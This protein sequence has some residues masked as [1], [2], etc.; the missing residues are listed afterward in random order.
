MQDDILYH[1]IVKRITKLNVKYLKIYNTMIFNICDNNLDT[2]RLDDSLK[3]LNYKL[4][5]NKMIL[6]KISKDYLIQKSSIDNI[7]YNLLYCVNNSQASKE[8]KASTRKLLN[9]LFRK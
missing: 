9:Y 3:N 5:Y 6:A 2:S 7:K 8:N 1:K 4:D